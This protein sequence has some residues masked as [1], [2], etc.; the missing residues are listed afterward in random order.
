MTPRAA[1]SI[2]D[3]H[4]SVR[5]VVALVV[6]LSL[7]SGVQA[8]TSISAGQR[9]SGVL[10]SQKDV[11]D[12][13]Y[14][15][16]YRLETQPGESFRVT[17]DGQMDTNI[18]IGRGYDCAT[19]TDWD[20]RTPEVSPRY[21]FGHA[22]DLSFVSGGG[23]YL[24]AARTRYQYGEGAYTLKVDRL[25][26]PS[27]T[28]LPAGETRRLLSGTASTQDGPLPAQSP[29]QMLSDC[30]QC[31]EL[32][33]VGPGS[34]MM[35]SPASEDGRTNGEG[36][37]RPV[38]IGRAFAIGKY[39]TT[40]E[41]YDA[42]VADGGCRAVRDSGFGRGRRPVINVSHQDATRYVA[43]LSH[44]T[45]AAYFLP[46]EAEWEYVAR[47][48][49]DTPWNT[50]SALLSDDANILDQFK[51]T[52]SVGGYPPNAW[53]LYD[54]HGNVAEWVQD[55]VDAGYVGA[56]S[57]GSAAL[58]GDCENRRV[59]RGGHYAD[60]PVRVRSAARAATASRTGNVAI[61]FRVARGL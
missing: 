15:E 51:K 52:V 6:S 53:G 34:F 49:S 45:G 61:G 2:R 17:M 28:R 43:W 13:R 59:F 39:E 38:T 30:D 1:Y 24:V 48:G 58:S 56:P 47:A 55:C 50:G 11:T 33:V 46:S 57:D 35:G 41:Q 14:T 23:D 44:K 21:I 40:F 16:C 60:V 9:V 4:M 31:P 7:A 19:V 42:C 36:P 37:R 18:A 8:Q 22:I 20:L 54:V 32:V 25:E 27:G 10:N 5:P 26:R 3:F 29:G 12:H